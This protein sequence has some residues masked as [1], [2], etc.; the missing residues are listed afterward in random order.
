MT[1][2]GWIILGLVLSSAATLLFTAATIS[3]QTFSHVRLHEAFKGSAAEKMAERL[4]KNA[5]RWAL[6]CSS[7]RLILNV[8]VLVLLMRAFTDP[9]T[10]GPKLYGYF[11]AAVVGAMMLLLLALA[12]PNAIA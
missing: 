5:E 7:Y 9:G 1:E 8:T 10:P 4:V 12:I 3:L 11:L 2:T 6:T